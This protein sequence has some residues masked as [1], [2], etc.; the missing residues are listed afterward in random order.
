M[1]YFL[2]PRIDAAVGPPYI[3]HSGNRATKTTASSAARERLEFVP[4]GRRSG[5]YS[6]LDPVVVVVNPP[7]VCSWIDGVA[8]KLFFLGP[9]QPVTRR[10]RLTVSQGAFS[11]IYGVVSTG[12]VDHGEKKSIQL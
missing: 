4:N 6:I 5:L 2:P 10:R 12:D 8:G 7:G 3:I 9:V 11:M 1:N